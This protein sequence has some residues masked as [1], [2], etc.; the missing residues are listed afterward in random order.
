[1][2][3]LCTDA[4]FLSICPITSS[5]ET[6]KIEDDVCLEQVGNKPA[7]ERECN[8][9]IICPEWYVGRWSPVSG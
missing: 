2:N 5:S 8:Q 4:D 3:T 1:M 9:G 7:T 6:K